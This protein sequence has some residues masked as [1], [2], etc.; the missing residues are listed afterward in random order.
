MKT[1]LR[2]DASAR[3]EGSYSRVLGD[4]YE[5]CWATAHPDGRVI[6]RDLA[7]DPLPHLDEATV[8][9]LYAGGDPGDGPFP[10]GIV[11]SDTLIGE[12]RSADQVVV[13]SAVY[14]FSITSSLKAWIDHIV[15]FGHTITRGENGVSGLLAGRCVC[16][17]TA[18]GG[19]AET[20]PEYQSATLRA[21]FQYIGF[22]R[23]DWISLEGT[24]I[25]DG[26]LEERIEGA[27]AAVNALFASP[28]GD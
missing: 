27:R 10:P 22:S 24:K 7:V 25:P 4:H 20:S 11:L 8:A 15:R 14:N 9:V 19:N 28:H 26:R 3:R 17:L 21:V 6:R 2:I 13:S 12:L 1:L 23:I 5:K 16:L 18:R